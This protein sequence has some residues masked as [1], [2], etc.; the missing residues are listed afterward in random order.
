[1]TETSVFPSDRRA[2][3]IS[4]QTAALGNE[5]GYESFK[6]ENI[7][8]KNGG[9]A[10]SAYN[11]THFLPINIIVCDAQSL[12]LKNRK[13]FLRKRERRCPR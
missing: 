4:L 1:V 6:Q 2:Y 9:L 13:S 12:T 8:V 5:T 7:H 10:V 11:S 3:C